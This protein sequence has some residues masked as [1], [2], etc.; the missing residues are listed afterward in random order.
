MSTN[1][2]KDGP[3]LET[4]SLEQLGHWMKAR[5]ESLGL[6]RFYVANAGGVC[7]RALGRMER[8]KVRGN[9]AEIPLEK[10]FKLAFAVFFIPSVKNCWRWEE[11]TP[12]VVI[13]R[14]Q[15]TIALK[16]ISLIGGKN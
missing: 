4:R 5:R 6:S 2:A 16:P 12:L 14:A 1:I 9:G 7:I 15:E 8:G 11:D 3:S 10:F 13:F